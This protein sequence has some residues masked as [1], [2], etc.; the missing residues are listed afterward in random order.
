MTVGFDVKDAYEETATRAR[1]ILPTGEAEYIDFEPNSQVTKPFIQEFFLE[2][3]LPYDTAQVVGGIVS[4]DVVGHK[5]I[6]MNKMANVFENEV[7]EVQ[8]VYYKCNVSGELLRPSG[9]SR[10]PITYEYRENFNVIEENVYALQTEPLF[11]S[12]TEIEDQLGVM[13]INKDE[14]Y[15]PSSYGVK[16]L[17]R[18]QP[19]SG[20]YYMV[21]KVL[22]RRFAGVDVVE[23]IEDNR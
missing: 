17:D 12:D 11:G 15:I 8:S 18:Y 1:L 4:L 2:A 13:A 20:E 16:E 21:K 19:L 10:D 22:R 6:V 5:Y 14:L 3:S 7:Y 9:E 23:L